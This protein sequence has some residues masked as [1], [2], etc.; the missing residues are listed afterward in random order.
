[1]Y[2]YMIL[3]WKYKDALQL[4]PAAAWFPITYLAFFF[5]IAW[6]RPGKY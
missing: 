2:L 5:I 1:M 4:A 6:I 3:L